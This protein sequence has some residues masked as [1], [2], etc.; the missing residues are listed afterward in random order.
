MKHDI[1]FFYINSHR[2]RSSG[3]NVGNAGTGC[4]SVIVRFIGSCGTATLMGV[5]TWL[6][7]NLNSI[8]S[9]QSRWAHVVFVATTSQQGEF[10]VTQLLYEFLS[11]PDSFSWVVTCLLQKGSVLLQQSKQRVVTLWHF[12]ALHQPPSTALCSFPSPLLLRRSQSFSPFS[13]M[14][15]LKHSPRTMPPTPRV[16]P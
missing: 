6:T 13:L 1:T 5:W 16:L 14:A 2:I 12:T 7:A 10:C 3:R 15:L 4:H 8:C 11:V 9:S